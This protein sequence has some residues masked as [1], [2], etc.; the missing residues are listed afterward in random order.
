MVIKLNIKMKT[1]I[2]P[3]FICLWLFLNSALVMGARVA[4]DE[5]VVSVTPKPGRMKLPPKPSRKI[6]DRTGDKKI[7]EEKNVKD[8]AKKDTEKRGAEARFV[9]IDF[10][11][12]DIAAFVKF[13][14][15]LT[16]KNFVIDKAVKGKVTIISPTKISV[17]EAYKVF[18]SV[19]EV[20]GFTTIPSGSIIKIV[21]MVQARSK[22]METSFLKRPGASMDKAH[23]S[24]CCGLT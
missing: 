19:L 4:G 13:I 2:R 15:E 17:K 18:C 14:S 22:D 3:V 8:R 12:V 7:K 23:K 20:H 11:D 1:L 9:T 24:K 5:G 21:P 6:P 16:G 10:D